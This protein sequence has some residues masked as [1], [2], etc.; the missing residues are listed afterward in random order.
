MNRALSLDEPDHLRHRVLRR[1]RDEHVHVIGHQMPL[2]YPAFPLLGQPSENLPK[3]LPQL[4]IQRAPSALRYEH[5]VV[6]AH[7]HVV[8]FK[9]SNLSIVSLPFV[10]LAAH[11]RKSLRWTPTK[12]SNFYCHPGRA[13]GPPSGVRTLATPRF[14]AS[15]RGTVRWSPHEYWGS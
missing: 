6:F 1:Y 9:L 11:D 3:V 2:L 15:L 12:T 5:H 8:W 10:C 14:H 13:G 7:T 4:P